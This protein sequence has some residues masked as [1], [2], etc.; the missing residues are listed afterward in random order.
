MRAG[1]LTVIGGGPSGCAAALAVLAEGAPVT[2]FEK[3][4]AP[5]HKVCG[6]FLSPEILPI[7][8]SLDLTAAFFAAR[9][10]RLTHAVLHLGR[11][12]KQFRLPEPAYSLSRLR[13]DQLMLEAASLRGAQVRTER[14]R[15][16]TTTQPT[17]LAYGRQV[18]AR[19]GKR[20]FGFKAHFRGATDESVEMYFFL[21]GYVGISPVEDGLVNVCGLAPEDL[22]TACEFQPERLFPDRLRARLQTLDRTFEWLMTGPLVYRDQFPSG[23][24][25]YAAGDALGFIDPFTGSGI[26][27]ALLTGRSA[28]QAAVRGE[29]VEAHNGR[30]RRILQRQYT[31]ASVLR[32]FLA[33]GLAEALAQWIP[34]TLLYRLTRPAHP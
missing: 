19:R 16:E 8:D 12:A 23:S 9:P 26:L 25:A 11:T 6:E 20:L 24:T 18:P 31:V 17:V 4:R 30:C 27:S 21:G 1:E 15:P 32:G 29:S 10:V 5:R 33:T 28:G 22:L 14:L 2:V 3:S 34:G 13:L 7:L